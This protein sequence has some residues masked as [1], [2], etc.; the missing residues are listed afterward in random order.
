[1]VSEAYKDS[2]AFQK[3]IVEGSRDPG[4]FERGLRGILRDS[5]QEVIGSTL[6]IKRSPITLIPNSKEHC[7]RVY[8]VRHD[9]QLTECSANS[10]NCRLSWLLLIFSY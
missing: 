7:R 8:P 4:D 10:N 9:A 6:K 2:R 5:E 1:M 3:E